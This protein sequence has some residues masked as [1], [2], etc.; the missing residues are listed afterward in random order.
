MDVRRSHYP[1]KG[2]ARVQDPRAQ[3]KGCVDELSNFAFCCFGKTRLIL[4]HETSIYVI[5]FSG[6]NE[7]F[8]L[9]DAF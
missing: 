4:A 8:I 9:T 3:L 6:T 7:K 2:R 5:H 1:V